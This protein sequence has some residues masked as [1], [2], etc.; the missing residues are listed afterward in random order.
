MLTAI[1]VAAGSSRRMGFDKLSAEIAGKPVIAHTLAAFEN[2][3]A[4]TAIIIVARE[5]R[6]AEIAKIVG[7]ENFTKVRSVIAGGEHRQDSVAAGLLQLGAEAKYVAVHDAARPLVTT[8]IIEQVFAKAQESGAASAAEGITDTLKRADVD[9]AVKESVN[10]HQL[11]GMQTPQIFERALINDAYRAIFANNLL[12]TDE[13]S[14]VEHLGRKVVLVPN[15][16]FNFKV[17]FPRDLALA[18]FVLR[19]RAPTR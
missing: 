17:T 15:T 16:D 7:A 18:E 13:V 10:R 14:A 12:I 6:Q 3:G 5:D 11:F 8:Q 2:S 1:I 9:L 19:Q 4:I